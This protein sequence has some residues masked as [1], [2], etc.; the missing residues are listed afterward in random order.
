[1]YDCK[2]A[3]NIWESPEETVTSGCLWEGELGNYGASEERRIFILYACIF[4]GV[5]TLH[6]IQNNTFNLNV[7]SSNS[8]KKKPKNSKVNNSFDLFRDLLFSE[9]AEWYSIVESL[10]SCLEIPPVRLKHLTS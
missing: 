7:K 1:M 10:I 4:F 6:A 9:Q 3:E 2:Y 5:Y 8:K